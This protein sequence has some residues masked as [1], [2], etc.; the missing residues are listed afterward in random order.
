MSST[1][2]WPRPVEQLPH[3]SGIGTECRIAQAAQLACLLE[4]SAPKPGNVNR[5]NDFP[6]TRF[7]DFLLSAVAIGPAMGCAGRTSVGQTIWRAVRDTRLLVGCNTN[8]GIVLLLAPLARACLKPPHLLRSR[9]LA[10]SIGAAQTEE[11]REHLARVLATL[12]VQDARRTYAAIRLAHPGGLGQTSEADVAE[13]PRVTLY[14]AMALA[15]ERDAVAREYVT[16]FAIT[17]GIGYPALR[18]AW[19]GSGDFSGAIVQAFLTILA[20]VPD[21]LIARK[22][23]TQVAAQVSGWARETLSLGGAF[24]APGRA[25]LRELDASL[26]DKGHTL[27]PGTTADLTTAAIFLL[28]LVDG[29]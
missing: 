23:G 4:V 15:Q 5:Q 17:F 9:S 7:E 2:R 19:Q 10:N 14:Q 12:T 27:N 16:D 26:R 20:L 22:R 11:L 1:P 25:S 6:D 29:R 3:G 18:S 28:L 24:T 21:T 13:E 8:L